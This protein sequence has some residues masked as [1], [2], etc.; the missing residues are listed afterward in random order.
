MTSNNTE[1]PSPHPDTFKIRS[2]LS[3]FNPMM[4]PG[5][6]VTGTLKRLGVS[7]EAYLRMLKRFGAGHHKTLDDLRTALDAND[8]ETARR[9]AHS[10]AGAAGNL[11]A[12]GLHHLAK[13][14]ELDL[15]EADEDVFHLFAK[16]QVEAKRVIDGIQGLSKGAQNLK[17]SP[18]RDGK[19]PTMDD[20]RISK[21]LHTLKENL[22]AGDLDALSAAITELSSDIPSKYKSQVDTLQNLIE[23]YEFEEAT[24]IVDQWLGKV[25]AT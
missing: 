6:D 14:L 12:E 20:A 9:H 25:K 11:G 17:D 10:I 22:G 16:L 13:E 24:E 7:Q 2:S 4:L 5:I 3:D 23:S 21:I 15:K 8:R 1:S 19:G 18:A